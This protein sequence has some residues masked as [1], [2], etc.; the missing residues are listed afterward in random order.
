MSIF[1]FYVVNYKMAERKAPIES[2]TLYKIGHKKRG[3]DNNIWIITETSGGIKR[4]KLFKKSMIDS[5]TG[6]KT[7]SKTK[8]KVGSKTKTKVGSKTGSYIDKT[9]IKQKKYITHDNGSR[10]FEI[11]TS[12]ENIT[13]FN[14][15]KKQILKLTQFLGY[16][17]GYDTS[18]N[19]VHH[20]TILIKIT[21]YKYIFVGGTVY[22]FVTKEEINDYVSI[23]GNSDVPYPIAFSESYLY[24]MEYDEIIYA[25]KKIEY[26]IKNS[27]KLYFIVFSL[28]NNQRKKLNVKM[29]ANR[30]F[31]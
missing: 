3:S 29:I 12:P 7:G 16:W 26:T 27:E 31:N 13:I 6:S 25:T 24:F 23:M 19:K 8:T 1:I 9:E 17:S 20:N 5:K 11:V 10:P 22:Q 21:K 4:W 14:R 18:P 30:T 15:S 28:P 2:A